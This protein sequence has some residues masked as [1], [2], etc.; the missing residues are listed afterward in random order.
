L[1]TQQPEA[2]PNADFGQID[3]FHAVLPEP[4]DVLPEKTT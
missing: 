1:I 2:N 4:G 3:W